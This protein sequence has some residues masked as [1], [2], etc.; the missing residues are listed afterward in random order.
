MHIFRDAPGHFI[1][2]TIVNRNLLL[3]TISPDNFKF[4]DKFGKQWFYETIKNGIEIWVTTLN[5]IIRDGGF[6]NTPRY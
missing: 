4:V 6:N 5:G 3:K 1:E 2:D